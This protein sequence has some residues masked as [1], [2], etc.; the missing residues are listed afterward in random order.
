MILGTTMAML[1]E[2]ELKGAAT[3]GGVVVGHALDKYGP[4]G[5]RST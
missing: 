3:V 2:L 5:P 1:P 4:E